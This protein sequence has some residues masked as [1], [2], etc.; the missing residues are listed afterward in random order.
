MEIEQNISAMRGPVNIKERSDQTRLLTTMQKKRKE[1][2]RKEEK[3]PDPT[4]TSDKTD[5]TRKKTRPDRQDY[6]Q[7]SMETSFRVSNAIKI[8]IYA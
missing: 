6:T 7:W 5:K 8:N 2:K 4:A 3:H 1:K